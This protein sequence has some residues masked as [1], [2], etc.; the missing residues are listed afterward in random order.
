MLTSARYEALVGNTLDDTT[1]MAT[2]SESTKVSHLDRLQ[3]ERFVAKTCYNL[4]A[5][6]RGAVAHLGERFNGI[7]EV[8]GSSP[9]SSTTPPLVSFPCNPLGSRVFECNLICLYVTLSETKGLPGC[10][11]E[12]SSEAYGAP[13]NDSFE[14]DALR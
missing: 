1:Q 8:R 7:E 13:Q 4:F 11:L 2:L 9:R 6:S 3:E 10:E 14:P 12:D 5:K